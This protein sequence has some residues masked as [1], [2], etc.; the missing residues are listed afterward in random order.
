MPK[1]SFNIDESTFRTRLIRGTDAV[2]PKGRA[3]AQKIETGCATGVPD[4]FYC[5]YGR[6]AWLELKVNRGRQN[7]MRISQWMW[8]RALNKAGGKGL[9]L[10]LRPH[11]KKIDVFTAR[12]L[13]KPE[14]FIDT[15]I[16]GEDVIFPSYTPKSVIN[17]EDAYQ[18]KD[19]WGY[20][21]QRIAEI[22]HEYNK[23]LKRLDKE[24][25]F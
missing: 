15:K 25:D 11:E 5:Y 6:A 1:L 13:S 19:A 10:I 4:V 2:E 21:N 12:E 20:A 9:L 8:M 22:L 7:Y 18:N 24:I 3:F 23:K 16:R 14:H 17:L